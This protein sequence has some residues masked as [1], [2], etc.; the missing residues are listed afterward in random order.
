M[1][2]R[3]NIVVIGIVIVAIAMILGAYLL[4]RSPPGGGL[5]VDKRFEDLVSDVKP[6]LAIEVDAVNA[7]GQFLAE[8]TCDGRDKTPSIRISNI[9][10]DA[11]TLALILYDPDA[12]RGTFIHWLALLPVGED[13]AVIPST[14]LIEGVNDF[15]EI[16]YGGPCPP[17]GDKAH[18]YFFLI[19]AL[20]NSP[21]LKSGFTLKEL[22]DNIKGHVI[23][24]G[25]IMGTYSR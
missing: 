25:Y 21:T 2:A 15:R 12:P 5:L 1:G 3:S 18:R 8:Y 6:E 19:L 23:A 16:G 9:P 22:L 17:R 20:D 10:R 14:G 11:K 13:E 7:N 24:Y 4:K